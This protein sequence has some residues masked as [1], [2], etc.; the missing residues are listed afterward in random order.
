MVQHDIDQPPNQYLTN[1]KCHV[2]A[3]APREIELA[4]SVSYHGPLK[5]QYY[6]VY[7]IIVK[8]CIDLHL[9]QCCVPVW[10]SV[11]SAYPLS[12]E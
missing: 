9:H 4:R 2:R 6:Q 3:W 10:I 1:E 11:I 12:G 7:N 5:M 8:K